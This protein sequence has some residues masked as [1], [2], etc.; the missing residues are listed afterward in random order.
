MSYHLFG[1]GRE[2]VILEEKWPGHRWRTERW[3]AFAYQFPNWT[4]QLPGYAW[5]TRRLDRSQD[6]QLDLILVKGEYSHKIR[7]L[8]ELEALLRAPMKVAP[9][10]CVWIH[11][12]MEGD[13]RH[14]RTEIWKALGDP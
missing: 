3:D 7:T 1:L 2:H 5:D 9:T 8:E 6:D 10:R 14:L 12:S 13:A 4:L 11:E